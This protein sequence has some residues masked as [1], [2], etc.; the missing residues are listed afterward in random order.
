MRGI[1]V[2]LTLKDKFTAPL[3]QTV[4][5]TRQMERQIKRAN[6]EISHLGDGLKAKVGGIMSSVGMVS[7]ALG[8]L[9]A[10]AFVMGGLQTYQDFDQAMHDVAATMGMSADQ[11]NSNNATYAMLE[12]T[13]RKMGAS[14]AFSAK[15]AADGLKFMALA[16]MDAET[17]CKALPSVLNLATAS[18]MELGRASDLTT[19]SLAALGLG[20]NDLEK[21]L[22]VAT[23]AQSKSNQST[24][25][26]MEAFIGA[27]SSLTGMGDSIESY[28]SIL[29]LL[30]NRGTKGAE[31]GTAMKSLNANL[32]A[33]A[34]ILAENGVKSYDAAGNYRG[35]ST[36]MQELNDKT[37]NMTQAQRDALFMSVAGKDHLG[38]FNK[39]MEGLNT[40]TADGKNEFDALRNSLMHASDGEGALKRTANT[41]S[42]TLPNAIKNVESAISEAQIT[43]FDA[44]GGELKNTLKYLASS[45][46]PALTNEL[47]YFG[48]TILPAIKNEVEYLLNTMGGFSDLIPILA[49]LG[50]AFAVSTI[51]NKV[52]SV[53]ASLKTI[54]VGARAAGGAMRFLAMANPFGVWGLAIGVIVMALIALYNRCEGFRTA[55]NNII[56]AVMVIFKSLYTAFAPM[57]N[58]IMEQIGAILPSI[59]DF[60]EAALIVIMYLVG[61]IIAVFTPAIAFMFTFISGVVGAISGAIGGLIEVFRGIIIFLTG[62][63]TGDWSKAWEGVKT[64]VSGVIDFVTGL[65]KGFCSGVMGAIDGIISAAKSIKLSSSGGDDN[66]APNDDGGD[67]NSDS[68]NTTPDSNDSPI[69]KAT[70]TSYFS[71][72]D[73]EVGEHGGE[74]INLP[75]GTQIIPHDKSIEQ[76][77]VKSYNEG[78]KAA[79]VITI[80]QQT[81]PNITINLK[82]LGNVIGDNE[83]ANYLGGVIYNQIKLALKNI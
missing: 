66:P 31:A 41:M 83:Y 54:Q 22:N 69:P 29:G 18:G 49:G 1:D 39:I 76:A 79:P 44:F 3:R 5:A 8:V 43:F 26:M 64:I 65:V 50:S 38:S 53:T 12:S 23:Q 55:V 80:P 2:L 13:A 7:G 19:D 36:I 15:E 45:T 30:A 9:G 78:Q 16:G 27:G 20:V 60:A 37:K 67:A 28:S 21:Y 81:V 57:V 48:Q 56:T 34:E 75:T 25:D 10:G 33:N 32:K 63:F 73:A 40:T 68:S 4:N 51:I 71:G 14:T 46:I 35:F 11:A 61:G 82:V 58:N 17:S 77:A 42:D 70:G 62:V 47:A 72:G 74:I 52:K 24:Q 59:M 6:N